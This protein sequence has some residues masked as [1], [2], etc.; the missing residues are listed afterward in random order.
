V[1]TLLPLAVLLLLAPEVTPQ[2]PD[3]GHPGESARPGGGSA[4]IR[5]EKSFDE[6]VRKAKSSGKP[7]LV[8]FWA[9]WCGWC[10][11]LDSTTYADATVVKISEQFVSVKVDAEGSTRGQAIAARYEVSS[12]PTIAFLSSHGR[13]LLRVNGFQGPGQFPRTMES[14]LE[15]ARRVSGWEEALDQHPDHAEA[16]AALGTH[17]FEQDALVESGQLLARAVRVDEKRPLLERKQ[18]RLLLG[19]I[20]KTER[21]HAEAERVL[22]AALVLPSNEL[23]AKVLYVLAK[24]YLAWGRPSD[25]RMV[26]IQVVKEHSANPIAEKA[27]ETLVMIEKKK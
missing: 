25:G 26:L 12:L 11:K 27:R 13:P 5:W 18:S 20:L 21:K 22:K 23:D 3:M 9:E 4:G 6:A 7:V 15:L 2:P 17:L 10:R 19:A 16:L 1:S 14:A 8:D 24:N